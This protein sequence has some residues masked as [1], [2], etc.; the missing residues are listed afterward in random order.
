MRNVL[1][2]MIKTNF[3]KCFLKVFRNERR[4]FES[5]KIWSTVIPN[6]KWKS[7]YF[8]LKNNYIFYEVNQWK[9]QEN[10]YDHHN[11]KLHQICHGLSKKLLRWYFN[12]GRCQLGSRNLNDFY[13]MTKI[14]NLVFD[15]WKSFK[16]FWRSKQNYH[17]NWWWN[18]KPELLHLSK[19][20]KWA[21]LILSKS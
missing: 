10:K 9:G 14:F 2:I 19:K 15:L 21:S 18:W 12:H 11:T 20:Q 16:N 1:L 3:I 8:I 6:T 13:K 4:I 7:I 5:W 17:K